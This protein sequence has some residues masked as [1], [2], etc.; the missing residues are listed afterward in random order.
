VRRLACCALL[1][2]IASPATAYLPPATAILKRSA[3]RREELRLHALEVRGTIAFSGAAADRLRASGV[4]APPDAAIPAVLQLKVPGR[5]RLE[6][7]PEGTPPAQRPTLA[8]RASRVTG[9]RGLG[10]VPA[11]RALAGAVCA[12]LAEQGAGPAPERGLAQ[13]LVQH[14]V[15]LREVSFGRE[16]GRVAWVIGGRPQDGRPQAWIDKQSLL[17]VRLVAAFGG[18]TRDVRLLELGGAGA[19]RFPRAIEVWGD[20]RLEARF[21]AGTVT[22]NPRLPD[23]LF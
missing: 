2:A 10:E 8:V 9:T 22:P 17:P 18:P 1:A 14:G 20:G 19:E 4:A 16:Q 5:C 15:D 23:A 6:L 13:R 7:A 11:A 21:T 3:Q 12:L